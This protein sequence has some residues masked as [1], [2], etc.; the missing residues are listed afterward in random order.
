MYPFSPCRKG[1]TD[2]RLDRGLADPTPGDPCF[3]MH[4][5]N[6]SAETCPNGWWAS[7]GPSP[8]FN[9]K[10]GQRGGW[11]PPFPPPPWLQLELQV[12]HPPNLGLGDQSSSD[13]LTF[14]SPEKG[15]FWDELMAKSLFLRGYDWPNQGPSVHPLVSEAKWAAFLENVKV[16]ASLW[17]TQAAEALTQTPSCPR[18][19]S[20]QG[21]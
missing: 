14:C 9:R 8:C 3:Q 10:D 6:G 1:A 20:P 2:G 4:L 18:I 16:P 13:S 12:P 7:W 15:C 11:K 21:P 5:I 19:I 17:A